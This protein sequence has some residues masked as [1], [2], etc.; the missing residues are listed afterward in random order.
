MKRPYIIIHPLQVKLVEVTKCP[1]LDIR[2]MHVV[3]HTR[4]L[5]CNPFV[6]ILAINSEIHVTG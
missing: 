4:F 3:S 6:E 5:Q 2:P 1:S